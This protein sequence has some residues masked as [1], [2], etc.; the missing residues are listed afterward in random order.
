MGVRGQSRIER[1]CCT[2]MLVLATWLSGNALRVWGADEQSGVSAVALRTAIA[3]SDHAEV[4][5]LAT[6][7]LEP[8]A[9]Q[10]DPAR[11]TTELEL[12]YVR[13]RAYFCQAQLRE[14]LAD[15]NR[16][17]ELDPARE[18][19]LWERGIVQYYL[20]QYAEGARQFELYQ[21][22]YDQD[23][24]NSVW[25]YLCQ[26]RATDAEQA[27]RQMLPI[28]RDRRVPLMEIYRLFRGEGTVD[29]VLKG[30]ERP[31]SSDEELIDQRF[32]AHLYLGLYYEA[33]GQVEQSRKHIDL[34]VDR[35]GQHRHYMWEVARVHQQLRRPAEA[36]NPGPAESPAQP[37]R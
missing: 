1:R 27:R 35:F 3:A 31:G 5:R 23:V 7:L 15:F 14:S 36:G 9:K 32:F 30:A 34:A 18:R 6:G 33:L 28:E 19:Q 12:R 2:A 17:I 11:L 4:I 13:G 20:G 25:R 21:T 16:M 37:A 22:Y 26:V 29:D 8:L 24:E 10:T